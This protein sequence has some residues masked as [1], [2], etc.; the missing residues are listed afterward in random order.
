M[1]PGH[2]YKTTFKTHYGLF[3]YLVMLF[4][5]TSVPSYP[6]SGSY[7]DIFGDLLNIS[8]IIYLDDNVI[9]SNNIE[10]HCPMVREV[11]QRLKNQGLYV[12]VSKCEFH[13]I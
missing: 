11:L 1:A 2:E 8:V 10:N 12:K 6:I 7:V 3:E 5:L 9:F 4:G 13:H